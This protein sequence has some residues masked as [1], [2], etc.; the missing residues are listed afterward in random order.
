M[1]LKTVNVEK[2]DDV[3]ITESEASLNDAD[4][5]TNKEG[6][7]PSCKKIRDASGSSST[8][9]LKSPVNKKGPGRPPKP[10]RTSGRP[11]LSEKAENEKQTIRAMNEIDEM[12][13]DPINYIPPENFSTRFDLRNHDFEKDLQKKDLFALLSFYAETANRGNKFKIGVV[14]PSYTRAIQDA[15]GTTTFSKERSFYG[16]QNAEIILCRL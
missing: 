2:F 13:F 3:L 12:T 11:N 16:S 6:D 8:K 10:K 14:D 7:P 15:N 9:T 4:V 1:I 5:E